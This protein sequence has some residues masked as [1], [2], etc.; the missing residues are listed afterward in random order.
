[1][2]DAP[3]FGPLS[4]RQP[5]NGSLGQG[6][7]VLPTRKHA[8]HLVQLYWQY[9]DPQ[10]H[11]L[12]EKR[13]FRSYQTLFTGGELDDDEHIFLSIL[14]TIFALS[15]QLQE[16]IP[17]EKRDQTSSTFFQLAWSLLRPETIIWEPGSLQL[18][19]CLLLICQYLQCTANPHQT[20]MAVGSAVRIAQSIGLHVSNKSS[21]NS[22]DH[23][24]PLR[25]QIWRR[26]VV[27]DR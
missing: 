21:S 15:T 14:N 25:R 19:Q 1:M 18:V 27:F 5:I 4:R 2:V 13:F 17:P 24:L 20:W 22:L 8:D 12:N 23:D 26:C 3:L 6:D 9:I 16:H 7:N 11:L 10:E